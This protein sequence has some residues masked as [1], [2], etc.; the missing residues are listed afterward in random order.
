MKIGYARVSTA[1]QSLDAQIDIL[2]TAG[3]DERSIYSDIISSRRQDRPGLAAA[4]KA[5]R[6]GDTLVVT[7]LDR[8]AR[9]SRDLHNIAGE[10][11]GIGADLV[12]LQQA[13]IDT[14]HSAGRLFFSM[15]AAIAE[16]ERDLIRDRTLDG[17]AAAAKRGRKGGRPKKLNP[18][19]IR[20]IRILLADP[21]GESVEAIA[22]QYG[23]DRSTLYR[24]IA[25]GRSGGS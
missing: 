3:V 9:S 19:Q 13:V 6:P 15:L 18:Q 25:G 22:Q 21:E 16:F 12:C 8:L 10:L 7:K 11:Q 5:L 17:L 24:H 14:T 23:V 2:Q 20:Q 1:D 4:I